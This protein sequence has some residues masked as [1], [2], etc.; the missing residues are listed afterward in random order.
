[1]KRSFTLKINQPCIENWDSFD[2]T[3]KG[4]FCGSCQKE[5]VDFTSMSDHQIKAY[6]KNSSGNTCGK[7]QSHQLKA[8]RTHTLQSTHAG[9]KWMYAGLLSGLMLLTARPSLAQDQIKPKAEVVS[10]STQNSSTSS[11][12]DQ[13][14]IARGRVMG[15][16]YSLPGVNIFIKGTT[17]GTVTDID[18]YFELPEVSPGDILVFSSIGFITSEYEVPNKPPHSLAMELQVPMQTL[19]CDIMGEVAVEEVY[20]EEPRGLAKAWQKIKRIF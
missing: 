17:L 11:T 14:F 6:F 16:A 15:E 7:F 5:V 12:P 18:G 8:Y 13:S 4:G 2:R 9:L 3:T 1:M 19:V 20:L 10:E